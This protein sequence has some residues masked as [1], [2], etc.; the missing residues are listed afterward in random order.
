MVVR[1]L[2]KFLHDT[3]FEE[4]KELGKVKGKIEFKHV[5]F[6]YK[7]EE[8]V[9]KDVSFTIEPGQSIAL[10]GKT[11]SRKNNHCEFD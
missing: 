11:G 10:V 3:N 1:F 8:W 5:W 2:K 4:G 6:A 7:G 9:L